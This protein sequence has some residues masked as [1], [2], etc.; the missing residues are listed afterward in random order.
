MGSVSD[1]SNPR[2]FFPL[3]LLLSAA[4]M[5]VSGTVKAIYASLGAPHRPV[6]R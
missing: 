3:G 4:V 6:R 2:Y 5:F 1:Q